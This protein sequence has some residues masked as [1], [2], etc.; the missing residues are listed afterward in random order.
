MRQI[1]WHGMSISFRAALIITN[2]DFPLDKRGVLL[3]TL[4]AFFQDVFGR[5]AQLVR[6]TA[7]QA[8]GH[9]FE[10]C[11]AYQKI[12]HIIGSVA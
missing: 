4:Q 3:Y 11:P 7:L 8:V 2:I 1:G 10:P 5:V 12:E 6:V 9:R